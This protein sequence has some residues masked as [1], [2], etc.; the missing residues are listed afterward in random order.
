MRP[1]C[2]APS[3]HFS[4]SGSFSASRSSAFSASKM[5]MSPHLQGAVIDAHSVAVPT[6][7]LSGVQDGDVSPPAG[8]QAN[9]TTG[10]TIQ[11]VNKKRRSVKLQRG[12]TPN[13]ELARSWEEQH[14]AGLAAATHAPGFE[15]LGNHAPGE[16]RL[17][18]QACTKE[19]SGSVAH[20]VLN[21]VVIEAALHCR[22][23][24]FATTIPA[25][26]RA[27]DPFLADGKATYP[28]NRVAHAHRW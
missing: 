25:S 16:Q 15:A 1:R 21:C 12:T 22:S 26:G 24:V 6:W 4:L 28:G 20:S 11:L 7:C 23:C 13:S 27:V 18:L 17:I 9:R 5:E 3:P 19:Q 10:A 8:G 14:V 2:T